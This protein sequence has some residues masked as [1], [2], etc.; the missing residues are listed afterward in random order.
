MMSSATIEPTRI[1]PF[2]GLVAPAEGWVPPLRYLLRRARS[3]AILGG[4]T[5]TAL[6]EAGC[7]AGALLADLSLRGFDCTGLE[8]SAHAAT[9]AKTLA[10]VSGTNY[11]IASEPD[12]VWNASFGV[13]CAF[14]VL[15]HIQDD[16]AALAQWCGWLR[17][18]GKLLVSVPAHSQRWGPG[19]VW[20]GH[21]RRYDREPLLKL[22]ASQALQIEHVECYGFPLA[23]LTEWIGKRTY[24]RLLAERDANVS[25]EAASAESGIQRDTY[26]RHFSKIDSVVGRLALRTNFLLQRMALRTDL[27]SGYLVLARKP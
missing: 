1:D 9:L 16:H 13:V 18:G 6:L 20:A 8:P 25:P 27:G 12:G 5:P 24:R 4:I 21:Y 2:F 14:D 3:L 11:R 26:L 7:G 23:N 10:S 17:P 22:L 19:D 15:E